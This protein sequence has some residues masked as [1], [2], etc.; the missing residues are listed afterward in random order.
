VEA[1]ANYA[2]G[3]S[4][5]GLGAREAALMAS[6]LPNPLRRSARTPGP[7]VRRLAITYIARAQSSGLQT[8]WGEAR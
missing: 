1:G 8:C 2:F 5:A 6:I 3:R 7:G 4:A